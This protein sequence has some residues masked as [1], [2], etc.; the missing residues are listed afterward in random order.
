MEKSEIGKFSLICLDILP[1]TFSDVIFFF[2][3]TLFKRCC[4]SVLFC[5]AAARRRYFLNY[6]AFLVSLLF[7]ATS[8]LFLC[9]RTKYELIF[10]LL[11]YIKKIIGIAVIPECR[12]GL[13]IYSS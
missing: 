12:V 1:G 2:V 13:K 8:L 5:T 3:L 7:R 9:I 6:F 4:L 11:T 10:T